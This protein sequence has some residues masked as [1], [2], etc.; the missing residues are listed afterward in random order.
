MVQPNKASRIEDFNLVGRSDCDQ[1]VLRY[2]EIT[3]NA[4]NDI[5]IHSVLVFLQI[6][7]QCVD[8]GLARSIGQIAHVRREEEQLTLMS[9]SRFRLFV[10]FIRLFIILMSLCSTN[11]D[12]P[13]LLS[14]GAGKK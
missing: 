1:E 8:D 12:L 10:S 7:V 2:I 5:E 4:T 14:E 6:Q 9:S 13:H 3:K 11:A